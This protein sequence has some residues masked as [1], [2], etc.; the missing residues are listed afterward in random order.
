MSRTPSPAQSHESGG[1]RAN[2]QRR[3]WRACSRVCGCAVLAFVAAF[4]ARRCEKAAS[5]ATLGRAGLP[6]VCQPVEAGARQRAAGAGAQACIG[7]PA[8]AR[9][10]RECS[11][12]RRL[13][14]PPHVLVVGSAKTEPIVPP[15]VKQSCL[16]PLLSQRTGSQC[17]KKVLASDRE[18]GSGA[19]SIASER[20]GYCSRNVPVVRHSFLT[21]GKV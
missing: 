12:P 20:H 3:A 15:S 4:A 17:C 8:L 13:A 1:P 21:R 7:L 2:Q 5:R 16:P 11:R 18:G 6:C 9:W 10:A 19:S 14:C